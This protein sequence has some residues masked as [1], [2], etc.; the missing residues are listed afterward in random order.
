LTS[1]GN[2][3]TPFLAYPAK[4]GA[5]TELYAGCSADLTSEKDQGAFIVPWG[6]RYPMRD[7]IEVEAWKEGGKGDRMW[8]W[9]EK[10]TKDY[11]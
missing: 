10:I 11:Q 6:R 2:I 4:L 8:E 3:V 9:C 5:Y 7:D 1:L